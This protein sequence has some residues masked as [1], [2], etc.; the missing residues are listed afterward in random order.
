[1]ATC[2]LKFQFFKPTTGESRLSSSL[3]VITSSHGNAR[4]PSDWPA[5]VTCRLFAGNSTPSRPVKSPNIAHN[6]DQRADCLQMPVYYVRRA[7]GLFVPTG[8]IYNGV[9]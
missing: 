2:S 8:A 9:N 4:R 1:M 7:S 6:G 5:L 3:G